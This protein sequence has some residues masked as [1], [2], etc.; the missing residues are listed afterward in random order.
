MWD[1]DHEGEIINKGASDGG[2]LLSTSSC[3]RQEEDTQVKPS[4]QVVV[5]RSASH[6]VCCP[7]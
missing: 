7:Q 1:R 3:M 6:E 4:I 2:P 5:L